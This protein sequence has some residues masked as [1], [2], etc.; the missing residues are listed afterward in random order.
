MFMI[1]VRVDPGNAFRI[2]VNVDKYKANAEYGMEV[3]MDE[4]EHV[5][6]FD[7]SSGYNLARFE[8]DMASK[9]YWGSSQMLSVWSVDVDSEA[10]WK[11]R[12]SE[13][14]ESMIKHRLNSGVAYVK[15]QVVSKAGYQN[16]NNW[17]NEGVSGVTN[18]GAGESCSSPAQSF[19][20]QPEQQQ[21]E[22][23]PQPEYIDWSTLTILPEAEQDGEAYVLADEEMVYEAMGFKAADEAAA[24]A[25]QEEETIPNIP[26]DVQQQMD[27][28]G[29][30]VDDNDPEEP[31]LDW[32]RDN[33]DMS[34]G[35]MYPNM[36]E[37]RLALKQHAI[38]TEF[39][40]GTE[41]SDTLR[42][43]GYC[44]AKGCG[45]KIRARRKLDG[46]VRVYLLTF[47]CLLQ[48]YLYMCDGLLT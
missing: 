36:V 30:F 28:A 5:V 43:R 21:Q 45:W 31:I 7:K 3:D 26:P 14:F 47:M 17:T 12:K 40:L 24:E 33:P 1:Y 10:S 48:G 20:A 29:I 38:V 4:Q 22:Q 16:T 2:V 15:V 18:E 41:K 23:Q 34:V 42:F 13:H 6:W 11:I 39:E 19:Q 32:D 35:T 9:I 46:C 44:K 27:E 25:A 8:A 37:F